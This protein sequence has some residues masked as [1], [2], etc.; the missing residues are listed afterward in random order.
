M[1]MSLR[2]GLEPSR[3]VAASLNLTISNDPNLKNVRAIRDTMA[4]VSITSLPSYIGS[5]ITLVSDV[6]KV[7]ARVVGMPNKELAL[8]PYILYIFLT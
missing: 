8:I 1:V 2:P 3:P 7:P 6:I 5:R 4:A